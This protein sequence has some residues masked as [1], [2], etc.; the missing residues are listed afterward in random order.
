MTC[1]TSEM[2]KL[3]HQSRRKSMGFDIKQAAFD[4]QL[5]DSPSDLGQVSA[6][7]CRREN[8]IYLTD[9]LLGL[10]LEWGGAVHTKGG[11]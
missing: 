8:N 7:I 5:A 2:E 10:N 4:S 9:L 11:P 3:G 6:L 1:L